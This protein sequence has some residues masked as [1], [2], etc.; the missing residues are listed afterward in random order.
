M[1]V[2]LMTRE[3]DD[4]GLRE[5]IPDLAS[6]TDAVHLRHGDVHQNHVRLFLAA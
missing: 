4:G 2:F 5:K 1:L 6:C 3:D